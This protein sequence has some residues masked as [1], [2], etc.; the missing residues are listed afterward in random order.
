MDV[1][2]NR[3][4]W[5]CDN[6]LNNADAVVLVNSMLNFFETLGTDKKWAMKESDLKSS[7][8]D[9]N[10]AFALQDSFTKEDV[11]DSRRCL[12]RKLLEVRDLTEDVKEIIDRFYSL[13]EMFCLS[14]E[15]SLIGIALYSNNQVRAKDIFHKVIGPK[16]EEMKA[17]DITEK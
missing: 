17:S 11:P 10:E 15:E 12:I 3:A 7:L 13:E 8:L 2:K 5:F 14:E 16:L 6:L 1:K 4:I 9:D